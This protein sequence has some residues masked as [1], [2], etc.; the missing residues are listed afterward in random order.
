MW[1]MIRLVLCCGVPFVFDAHKYKK[2]L[3]KK[4]GKD[5]YSIQE[6]FDM[7]NKI[8][9]NVNRHGFNCDFIIRG[10]ENLPKGQVLFVGNHQAAVDPVLFLMY[11]DRP[12]AFLA[13]KEIQKMPFVPYILSSM[14]GTFIDRTNLRSE[15]KVFKKINEILQK[16]PD[17]SYFVFPEGTRSKGPDYEVA[18]FHGGSFKIAT[19]NELPIC[20]VCV[21]LTARVMDQHYHY[22]R[23]PI[24]VTYLDPIYPEQYQT[25]STQELA[26]M[27]RDRVKEELE[28]MKERDLEL[29]MSLNSYSEEKARKIQRYVKKK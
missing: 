5:G 21:Y 7:V 22:H 9:S 6:R 1:K 20:P 29:I 15:V 26:D 24:Q 13:K 8:V 25:M 19:R 16:H 28:K 27:V 10:Q 3:K 12:T 17:T 14:E 23:Y 2:A 11:S 18:P 4:G